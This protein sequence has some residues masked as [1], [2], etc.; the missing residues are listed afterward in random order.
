M[1]HSIEPAALAEP[2]QYCPTI[3]LRKTTEEGALLVAVRERDEVAARAFDVPGVVHIPLSEFERRFAELPRE[4]DHAR[5]VGQ[6]AFA[7]VGEQYGLMRWEHALE[8]TSES[9]TGSSVR[10][11]L[12]VARG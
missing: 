9:S 7:V 5:D 10:S 4:F 12:S 1:K 3:T 11:P 6:A 8:V 2:A